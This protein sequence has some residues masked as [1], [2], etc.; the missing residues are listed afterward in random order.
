MFKNI[1]L[2]FYCI[3]DTTMAV[4]NA[5]ANANA[6]LHFNKIKMKTRQLIDQES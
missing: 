1:V 2:C 6:M 3:L 4:K 5:D